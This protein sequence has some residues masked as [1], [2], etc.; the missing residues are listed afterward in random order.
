MQGEEDKFP[1]QVTWSDGKGH[2]DLIL[3]FCLTYC[4]L[5]VGDAAPYEIH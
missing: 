1:K 5:P 2:P 4:I 3:F